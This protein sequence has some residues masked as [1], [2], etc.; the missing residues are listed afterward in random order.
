MVDGL[1][2]SEEGACV[3]EDCMFGELGDGG[4]LS[5]SMKVL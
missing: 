5:G 2:L 4:I 1:L 3:D